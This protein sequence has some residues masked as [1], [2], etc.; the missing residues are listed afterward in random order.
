MSACKNDI[1]IARLIAEKVSENG[2][3][4]YFVGGYVRD[5]LRNIE[6]TENKDIDIEV[7]GIDP[8]LLES[9]LDG[10]GKRI[11]IGESFGIYALKGHNIDIALPR[12]EKSF[13]GGH[14]DFS[15]IADPFIGTYEAAK[16]RDFT[17]NAIMQDILT[18]NIID[19]FGGAGDLKSGV[20]RHVDADTFPEDPLRVFRAAQFAARFGFTVADETLALCSEIAIDRLSKERIE[21]ELKK[22]LLKS[23]RPSMFFEVLRK[24]NK[25]S[26]WFEEV[27]ALI[28]VPQNI[29]YHKEGDVWTHTMMVL[30]AAAVF[31]DK[32]AEPFAFM[33]SALAHDLGKPASTTVANGITHSYGHES[34]GIE[35]AERLVKRISGE[36]MLRRYVLNM[37][38]NHMKPN[39]YARNDAPVKK[40]NRLFDSSVSSRDLIYL[41]LSDGM[42]K[43][44]RS[45]TAAAE[46]YLL[47]RLEIYEGIMS[48]PHVTGEDLIQAGLRPDENFSE[49]LGYAHKLR[50]AGIEKEQALKQTL[51][52]ARKLAKMPK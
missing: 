41:A 31:R 10:I 8:T 38:Q 4:A 52:L 19:H 45:D 24:M 32:T 22:A 46:K 17:V 13:G 7:H 29:N 6:E 18:G 28:G 12:K 16:R 49:L 44:P 33:L 15:V 2:G 43:I 40:T 21:G 20:L 14:R 26:P 30:D 37:V 11:E 25:L 27:K 42:G 3:T 23:Q 35:P 48:A 5:M 39:V 36:K 47:H 9:I 50:L 51:S 34:L 1:G